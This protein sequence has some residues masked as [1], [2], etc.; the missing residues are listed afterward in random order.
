MT[1]RNMLCVLGVLTAVNCGSSIKP[2]VVNCTVKKPIEVFYW[3]GRDPKQPVINDT[4]DRFFQI[5][6]TPGHNER[7]QYGWVYA[8]GVKLLRV[9]RFD[10]GEADELV[11][12]VNQE[13]KQN[14]RFSFLVMFDNRQPPPRTVMQDPPGSRTRPATEFAFPP[15]RAPLPPGFPASL[16]GTTLAFQGTPGGGAT[17]RS[18]TT[19]GHHSGD[20]SPPGEAPT[21][22]ALVGNSLQESLELEHDK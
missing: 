5:I 11:A 1:I 8:N 20:D 9:Y 10:A 19:T 18:G 16:P 17:T 7:Q 3:A 14:R 12:A 21:T 13:A 4:S 2:P 15:D 6:V 22:E